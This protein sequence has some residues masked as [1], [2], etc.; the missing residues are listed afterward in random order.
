MTYLLVSHDADV[1]A[2]MSDRAAFMAEGVIQRFFDREALVNG[3]HRMRLKP[4]PL[5]LRLAGLQVRRHLREGR[6]GKA[7]TPR[8]EIIP[9]LPGSRS[10]RIPHQK[11]PAPF[12]HLFGADGARRH[13]VN[14]VLHHN[15]SRP[16]SVNAPLMAAIS[17]AVSGVFSLAA[18]TSPALEQTAAAYVADNRVLL[19]QRFQPP[20]A[21]PRCR[22]SPRSP[23]PSL[24]SSRQWWRQSPPSPAD[25]RNRST[26]AKKWSSK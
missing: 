5:A 23:P 6:P 3:E 11:S 25:G 10:G 14:A 2:H 26:P 4:A 21:A 7:F 12:C 1:I 17:A 24:P 13:H 18:L 15:A 8:P 9:Y 20:D 22:W 19:P 16:A